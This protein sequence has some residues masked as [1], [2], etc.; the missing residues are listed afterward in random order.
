M[1][2]RAA[3]QRVCDRYEVF[4]DDDC[5]LGRDDHMAEYVAEF[6][7]AKN[8]MTD[9]YNHLT[10][11][12]DR[13]GPDGNSNEAGS[14]W[15]HL[16]HSYIHQQHVAAETAAETALELWRVW[17]GWF[18]SS[19]G[20]LGRWGQ[21]SIRWWFADPWKHGC[22]C[23]RCQEKAIDYGINACEEWSRYHRP[24]VAPAQA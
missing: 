15:N 8:T 7:T 20:T 19:T 18:S 21:D 16:H 5:R 17:G 24:M 4:S 12:W 1:S 22:K 23:G 11:L 6:Q 2:L 9:S 14:E 3:V 13:L 10:E